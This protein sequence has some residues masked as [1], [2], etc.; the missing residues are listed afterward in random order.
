[1][2]AHNHDRLVPRLYLIRG[3]PGSGKTTYANSLGCI[4]IAPSDYSSHRGGEYKWIRD[5]Y[6]VSKISWR[7]IVEQIMTLQIDIAITELM[8]TQNFI[9]FWIDSAKRYY[10]EVHIKTLILDPEI[11]LQRNLHGAD[12]KSIMEVHEQF[13]YTIKD[14]ILD[15]S[16]I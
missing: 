11:C 16:N 13:D 6:M 14:Q 4:V 1:M 5:N 8:P 10:Y 15:F 12:H 7:N 3:L 2:I 9:N